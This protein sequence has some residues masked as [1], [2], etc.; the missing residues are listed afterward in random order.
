MFGRHKR[1][2]AQAAHTE[3]RSAEAIITA[4]TEPVLPPPPP[5]VATT[6]AAPPAPAPSPAPAPAPSAAESDALSSADIRARTLLADSIARMELSLKMPAPSPSAGLAVATSSA[7]V[8]AL[9]DSVARTASEVARALEH[10][11]SMCAMLSERL[12]ADRE[13]RRAL[14]DAIARLGVALPASA[15]TPSTVLGGTVYPAAATAPEPEPELEPAVF[16]AAVIEAT[17]IEAAV[18]ELDSAPAISLLD[19]E[20]EREA[21]AAERSEAFFASPPPARE[22]DDALTDDNGAVPSVSMFASPPP[23]REPDFTDEPVAAFAA[24]PPAREPEVVSLVDEEAAEQAER[25]EEPVPASEQPTG[26]GMWCREDDQ[27]I[28]GVEIADF[29]SDNG[30]IR[31]WLRRTSDGQ[32]LPLPFDATDLRFIRETA[33]AD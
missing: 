30:T 17:V 3:A 12:D 5:P 15:D 2:D 31:Y 22:R 1:T 24:P 13:E 27:W 18:I 9:A 7:A 8:E 10:V 23:A 19:E 29:V 26:A 14:T 28:G 33:P 16:E 25:V 4:A 11:S 21:T 20:P 6:P 32:M